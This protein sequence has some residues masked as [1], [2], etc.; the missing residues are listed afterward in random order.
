MTAVSTV[1]PPGAVSQINALLAAALVRP[2]SPVRNYTHKR[3]ARSPKS[4]KIHAGLYRLRCP[5]RTGGTFRA[6]LSAGGSQ[7]APR[8]GAS[9]RGTVVGVV[10]VGRWAREDGVAVGWGAAELEPP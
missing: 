8:R 3:D 2:V 4:L 6:V 5:G 7:N 10:L 9:G 1:P